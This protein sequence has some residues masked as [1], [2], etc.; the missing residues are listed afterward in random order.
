MS[1][2]SMSNAM[3]ALPT[4]LENLEHVLRKAEANIEERGIDADVI[5]N[6]RLAPDMWPLKK[7]VS[8]VAA[9]AKN[10]PYRVADQEPPNYEGGEETF[11]ELY[12]LLERA[13][14]DVA[15]VSAGDLDG[16]EGREFSLQMGPREME[17]TGISYLSGFTIPN[18]YFHVTT[19]YNILRH[20][21][22][23][24]G[25][26][27]VR[28]FRRRVTRWTP[29]PNLATPLSRKA[30]SLLRWPRAFFRL[31]FVMMRL[32]SMRGAAIAMM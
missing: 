31:N 15:A 26:F 12:A 1:K 17:F 10:A 3:S 16:Q 21:G 11:A 24:L 25:K 18:M 29:L 14:K 9:L 13:K 2:L 6:A 27:E 20:N 4:M 19:V 32:C 28:L 8:T 30:P 22:V 23:P 7:Q 5:L